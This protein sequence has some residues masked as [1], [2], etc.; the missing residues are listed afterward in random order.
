MGRTKVKIHE[1]MDTYTC[2]PAALK[3]ALHVLGI[4]RSFRYL[5]Q[6]CKTT[7]KEGTTEIKMINAVNKLGLT[8]MVV[9]NA[10]LRHL[11][12][13]LKY[14]PLKPRAVI[15]DWLQDLGDMESGHWSTVATY[16][17]RNSRIV[18]FDP[19]YGARR[20]FNWQEFSNQRWIDYRWVKK[21]V[22][23]KAKQVRKWNRKLM[24]II[25]KSPV[26]LPKFKSSTV[27]VFTPQN[28]KFISRHNSTTKPGMNLEN[29][30][31]FES[32]FPYA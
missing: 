29:E 6:I 3:T 23:T 11:Q 14:S 24:L 30:I 15:V 20:S 1:Q 25:A 8:V 5:K 32:A 10:N 18:L 4:R 26:N 19:S 7:K 17:S 9:T 22:G 12:S 2:G 13:S 27:K 16:S 28:L 31:R 21:G